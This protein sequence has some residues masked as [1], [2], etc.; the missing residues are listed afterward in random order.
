M[1]WVGPPAQDKTPQRSGFLFDQN[2]WLLSW[3]AGVMT[4]EEVLEVHAVM[5]KDACAVFALSFW[6]SVQF[7]KDL[8][9]VGRPGAREM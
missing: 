5:L 4:G 2:F 7:K 8:W 1:P 9:G 3:E 6:G